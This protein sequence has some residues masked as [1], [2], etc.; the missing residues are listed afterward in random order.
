MR[1]PPEKQTAPGANRRGVMQGLPNSN[2]TPL[3]SQ[4]R[5][6]SQ[7]SIFTAIP[8]GA[9]AWAVKAVSPDGEEIRSGKF[10]GRLAALGAAVLMAARAEGRVLP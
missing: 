9:S 2:W 3:D 6:A 1:R 4:S 10:E 5:H 8:I 7:Q